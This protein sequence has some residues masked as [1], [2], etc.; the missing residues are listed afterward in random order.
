MDKTKDYPTPDEGTH[1]CQLIANVTTRDPLLVVALVSIKATHT[2]RNNFEDTVDVLCQSVRSFKDN[3]SETRRSSD[4]EHSKERKRPRVGKHKKKD[5]N[6]RKNQ[7]PWKQN[8]S[9]VDVGGRLYTKSEYDKV[10]VEQKIK[11]AWLRD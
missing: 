2:L 7:E 3:L 1:V 4:F 11:L 6:Q 10:E 8:Y 9:G 5:K